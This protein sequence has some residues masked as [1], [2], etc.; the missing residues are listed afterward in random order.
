M[1][2]K[3]KK[4]VS[5]N[6]IFIFNNI[7]VLLLLLSYVSIYISPDKFW[8]FAFLGISYPYFLLVNILFLIFWIIKLN[9]YFLLSLIAI[10]IGFSSFNKTIKPFPNSKQSTENQFKVLSYNVRLFDVFKYKWRDKN[11]YDDRNKI[12]DFLKEENAEIVCLQE[13]FYNKSHHF[14]T[15]DTIIQFIDAKNV[16]TEFTSKN[17]SNYFYFGAATF[18]KYP[19]I[20]R[21]KI[22]FENK[23]D[24]ICIYSDIIKNKDTIRIYNIHLESIKLSKEDENFY[25]DFSNN[26][27]QEKL[28]KGS[29]KIFAK[30]KRAFIK[31]ASQARNLSDHIKKSPYPVILCGDFNDTPISYSYNKVSE[32]LKDAFLECG[33]G[34]G[35]TYNGKFPSFRIDYILFSDFFSA[36]SFEI[37][38]IDFSDHYPIISNLRINEK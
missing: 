19:I 37:K 3:Q 4:S 22:E 8:F 6:I 10:L 36:N 38:K 24:N 15:S 14:K 9:K 29:L 23:T 17:D 31:R 25:S 33:S 11:S 18:S 35:N 26:K 12:F 30:L 32:N 1:K 34:I 2:S 21:G 27:E 28:K 16:H 13:F 7:A 20:N 5:L